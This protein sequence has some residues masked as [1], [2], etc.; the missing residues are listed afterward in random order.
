MSQRSV[1]IV[2]AGIAGLALARS[3][4]ARKYAVTVIDRDGYACGASVRNFGMIWPVGQPAGYYD[5]AIRSRN[6]WRELGM[7]GAFWYKDAGSIHAAYDDREWNVL[8][9]VAEIYRGERNYAL[10]HKEAVRQRSPFIVESG[11]R[12][13]LYS[14]D[15]LIVDP[16]EALKGIANFLE[17]KL[18]VKFRWYTA[19][20]EVKNNCVVAADGQR[21]EADIVFVCTGSD[22]QALFP[23]FFSKLNVFKC[24][25]QMMRFIPENPANIGPA[26]CGGLS[27]CHYRSF[28]V[29]PS[30]ALLKARFEAE[31]PLYLKH[32]IHV[33]V[34][35]NGAGEL[36]IGDSHE[37]GTTMGPFDSAE[38]NEMVLAYLKKFFQVGPMKLVET[39]N[40]TYTSLMADK[41]YIF[42]QV[43]TAVYLFN[44]LGGSGMT[45]SFGLAEQ[46]SA[47]F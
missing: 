45:M 4:A 47:S 30:L 36:T 41:P 25:L 6:I 29:S 7:S 23:G 27:L 40:G 16:R 20:K 46:I 8:Q 15:E 44:G 21:Y 12:G 3:F 37:Y 35:Q 19:V 24:K 43:D 34:S 1:I 9:E 13:G 11:L 18:D 17:T 5:T 10:L 22:H 42:E 38:I 39:W 32:G 31:M 14:A 33:M 2:G 26:V 28:A